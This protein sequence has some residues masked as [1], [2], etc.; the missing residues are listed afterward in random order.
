VVLFAGLL[1]LIG[2]LLFGHDVRWS[3][4][5]WITMLGGAGVIVAFTR[6]EQH[7]AAQ[8]GMP[9]VDPALM[10]D[11]AFVRGLCAVFAFF[12]ANLSFYLVMTLFMQN[13]LHLPPL[14]AGLVFVPLALAFVVASRHS[15]VRAKHRG[16]MVLIEGCA[17]QLAG[18]AAVM[19]TVTL[20]DAPS[21][22]LLSAPLV[23]FGYGQGLVMAPLSSVV[24]A[25]VKPASAGSA[26]GL[27][28]TTT[29]IGNAAG[30][31]AFGAVYFAVQAVHAPRFALGVTLTL[32]ALSIAVSAALLMWMRR[33]PRPA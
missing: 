13:A 11:P 18:L 30:V 22:L 10:A 27:Y 33:A 14:S 6:L 15:G 26:S 17:V 8:G 9:L 20:V 24:L 16:T 7:V 25:T 32:I 19:L 23:V 2:P 31:A 5:V 29:Q 12:F 3:P 1:C 21:A 28:G 4:L